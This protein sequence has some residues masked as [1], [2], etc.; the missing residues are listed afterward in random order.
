M[1][2]SV[3]TISGAVLAISSLAVKASYGDSICGNVNGTYT[4]VAEDGNGNLITCTE[5][6]PCTISC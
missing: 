3:K 6:N 2:N 1:N 4:C 5:A